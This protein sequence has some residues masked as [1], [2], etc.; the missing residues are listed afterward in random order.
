MLYSVQFINLEDEYL[1]KDSPEIHFFDRSQI[2]N[3]GLGWYRKQM[4]FST[5]E[6]ITIEKTPS[7]FV[8]DK[9]P[10]R[11][12]HMNPNIKLLCVVRDP[13]IR[14]ISDYVQSISK[15][16]DQEPRS[17]DDL[18]F[19]AKIYASATNMTPRKIDFNNYLFFKNANASLIGV[20]PK[21]IDTSWSAIKIGIYANYL[22]R[23]LSYFPR[24]QIFF[25]DGEKLIQEPSHI[26]ERVENFLNI[27]RYMTWKLFEFDKSKKFPCIKMTNA[28]RSKLYCLGNTKGR[29]HP[30]VSN[31][32]LARLHNFYEPLNLRFFKMINTS[33]DWG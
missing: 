13:V 3:K 6:M 21:M 16:T 18:L 19:D 12:F 7:Y 25:V 27:T 22:A 8:T 9:A 17:F 26:M 11:I 15:K 33:F 10:Q 20:K 5:E 14:A 1:I 23:W 31:D 29:T 30:S 4:P 32:T 24:D 28:S 2:Y